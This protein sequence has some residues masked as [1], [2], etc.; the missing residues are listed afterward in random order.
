VRRDRALWAIIAYK[1]VKG[2]LWLLFAALI[3]ASMPMGLED[4]LL[5]LAA[6]LRHHAR[7]WS[8]DLA[9]LVVRAATRRGL[10]TIA[11]ALIADGA[12]SLVE[13]WALLHGKLWGA[14]LVVV[15]TGSPL[16]FEVV[17]LV[18]RPHPV[19]AALL[20]VNVAI[21][22]YLAQKAVRERHERALT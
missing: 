1:L 10:W 13:G 11:V 16:P 7:A 17:A 3:L 6:H 21:V 20:V 19:R 22:V 12:L 4:R 18:R 14:W 5:G 8:L 9:E 15:A 2:C